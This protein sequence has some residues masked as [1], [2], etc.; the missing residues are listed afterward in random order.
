[1][2]KEHLKHRQ[3][4]K[5]AF[6]RLAQSHGIGC[7]D[8]FVAESG[9]SEESG[10]L[11]DGDEE[12]LPTKSEL[13]WMILQ[14]LQPIHRYPSILKKKK[15]NSCFAQ[16]ACRLART[17]GNSGGEVGREEGQWERTRIGC[18]EHVGPVFAVVE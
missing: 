14:Y 13:E 9:E 17:T 12:E 4:A 5:E 16:A 8:F 7:E 1:M 2:P 11:E 15:Y 3:S 18:Q 10:E 6:W